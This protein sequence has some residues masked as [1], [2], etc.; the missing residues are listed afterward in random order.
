MHNSLF[1]YVSVWIS[2]LFPI[3][4]LL[5]QNLRNVYG[6]RAERGRL[7]LSIP[8][9]MRRKWLLALGAVTAS[10]VLSY[11]ISVAAAAYTRQENATHAL[12]LLVSF[13]LILTLLQIIFSFVPVRLY[14]NC[15]LDHLGFTDWY[16]LAYGEEGVGQFCL[17]IIE[18]DFRKSAR[19]RKNMLLFCAAEQ[20]DKVRDVLKNRLGDWKKE[21]VLD[22]GTDLESG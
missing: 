5:I 21:S 14:E 17:H 11:T 18:R 2:M 9:P 16:R 20:Q 19:F 15:V 12:F 10:A 3:L 6:F 22:H 1:H 7:L 4:L 13:L 8:V